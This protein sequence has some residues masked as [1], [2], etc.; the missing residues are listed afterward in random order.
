M[1]QLSNSS[2]SQVESLCEECTMAMHSMAHIAQYR[3]HSTSETAQ[4]DKCAPDYAET[5]AKTK[6]AN[7]SL[8]M[9]ART[10]THTHTHAHKQTKNKRRGPCTRACAPSPCGCIAG[11][12][13]H[14]FPLWYH[15]GC[16]QSSC[17]VTRHNTPTW[18]YT[19]LGCCAFVR[20]QRRPLEGIAAGE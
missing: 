17:G 4:G 12:C 10:H 13:G 18:L 1:T 16:I 6:P 3:C 5:R 9:R 20:Q 11:P 19:C 14:K 8:K 7:R 15:W 2:S